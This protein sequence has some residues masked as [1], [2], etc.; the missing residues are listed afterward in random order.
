MARSAST[1]DVFSA[2]AEPR[3]RDVLDL[4]S[5]REQSVLEIVDQLGWPQP[6][7]SKHLGVLRA[8][9]LVRVRRVGR[10]RFYRING[11]GMKA[12]HTWSGSFEK[13]WDH[14][15]LAIKTRAENKAAKK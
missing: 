14:Q 10:K 6:Q 15:L 9:D 3:R 11:T 12:I 8:V 7:V 2:I 4:L 13:W 1:L 5:K